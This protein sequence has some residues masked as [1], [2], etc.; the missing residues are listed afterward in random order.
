MD[1]KQDNI[2]ISFSKIND[3]DILLYETLN[4]FCKK[5]NINRTAFLKSLIAEALKEK[6]ELAMA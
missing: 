4:N 1:K 5:Q 3:E 2:N 6:N